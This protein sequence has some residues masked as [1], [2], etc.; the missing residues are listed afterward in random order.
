MYLKLLKAYTSK[1]LLMKVI[2]V[3]G[4]LS[5]KTFEDYLL[6][7][8]FCLPCLKCNFPVYGTIHHINACAKHMYNIFTLQFSLWKSRL[9]SL[10][11]CSSPQGPHFKSASSH[12]SYSLSCL[13]SL[14][15]PSVLSSS[16][17]NPDSE[18]WRLKNPVSSLNHERRQTE[19]LHWKNGASTSCILP[20]LKTT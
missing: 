18:S 8:D 3:F 13:Y 7:W 10:L 12:K 14:L 9:W 16:G 6:Y 11:M 2:K 1:T 20:F 17:K 19:R 4:E 5:I 15:Q